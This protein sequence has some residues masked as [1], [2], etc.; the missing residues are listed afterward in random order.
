MADVKV[1]ISDEEVQKY[2]DTCTQWSPVFL[3]FLVGNEDFYVSHNW[4]RELGLMHNAQCT[5]HDAQLEDFFGR[6]N[7]LCIKHYELC[8]EWEMVRP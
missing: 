1:L 4:E 2:K 5:M 7:P 6:H 8:I 3:H